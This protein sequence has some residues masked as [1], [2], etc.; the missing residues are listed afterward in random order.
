MADNPGPDQPPDAGSVGINAQSL[1][2]PVCRQ[3]QPVR[4]KLLLVLPVGE[5]FGYYCA[6]CG[7]E[8][9]AK[10]EKSQAAGH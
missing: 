2:C 8:L 6:V 9:G 7:A 3:A 5:K 4:S 1:Y 10:L